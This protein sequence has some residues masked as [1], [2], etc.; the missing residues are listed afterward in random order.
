M[1]RAQLKLELFWAELQIEAD[2]SNNFYQI[3]AH[4]FIS[5]PNSLLSVNGIDFL[6]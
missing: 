2:L 1:L 6:V 3:I 4:L 5:I